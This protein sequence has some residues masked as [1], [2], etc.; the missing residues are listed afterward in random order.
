MEAS[1]VSK[2]ITQEDVSRLRK[3]LWLTVILALVVMILTQFV[4]VAVVTENVQIC[5]SDQTQLGRYLLGMSASCLWISL[6]RM[7]VYVGIL[8][9]ALWLAAAFVGEK[10]IRDLFK[11]V[12]N[13]DGNNAQILTAVVFAGF[14][15]MTAVN[16][17]FN[18][19]EHYLT[20]TA[21]YVSRNIL[22]GFVF[23]VVFAW[24]LGFRNLEQ[25]LR[26]QVAKFSDALP[27]CLG[28]ALLCAF[29][30]WRVFGG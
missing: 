7:A 19:P 1:S 21:F 23:S 16:V 4:P 20:S 28:F 30:F 10:S 27:Y 8:A 22:T 17:K 13:P 6:W 3:R 29:F 11:S 2:L 14:I 24:L 26:E 25:F 18:S 5:S 15:L 12:F 9:Y